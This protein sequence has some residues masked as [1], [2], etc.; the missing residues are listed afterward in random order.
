MKKFCV[1]VSGGGSNLQALIDAVESGDIGAGI[2]GVVSSRAGAY[3]LERAAAH[4]IPG[5]TV[6]RAGKP[7]Q[8]FDEELL[9][10]IDGLQP[11]FIVLAGF[12]TILGSELVQRY[13]NRII[14]IHPALIPSFCGKGFYGLRVHE[15]VLEYGVKL[16]GA[17]VHFVDEGADTGAIIMQQ[18]VDVLPDDTPEQLQKRVLGVEH[19]LLPRAV[20]LMAEGRIAVKGRRVYI[21]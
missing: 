13:A 14:N 20:A 16:S 8:Q 9:A 5:I 11:D 3:A 12:M 17:T 18:A 10:A 6:E 7:Q 4:G 15:A 1:L 2:C 19:T 21:S